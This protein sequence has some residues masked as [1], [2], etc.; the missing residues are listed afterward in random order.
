M[1][2]DLFVGLIQTYLDAIKYR[3]DEN[4]IKLDF[5]K[6]QEH[7]EKHMADLNEA[8]KIDNEKNRSVAMKKINAKYFQYVKH[9]IFELPTI[10][11]H[12]GTEEILPLEETL[13]EKIYGNISDSFT[14]INLNV[15]PQSIS[16]DPFNIIVN[17]M[18]ANSSTAELADTSIS[19]EDVST[20]NLYGGSSGCA[21]CMV[22]GKS[23]GVTFTDSRTKKYHNYIMVF[24][25]IIL[26][27]YYSGSADAWKIVEK[28][29]E[30]MNEL[31]AGY[32]KGIGDFAD[33][34][35]KQK[36][37]KLESILRR[38]MYDCYKEFNAIA[39]RINISTY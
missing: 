8:Q 2:K 24:Y 13:N 28:Y 35:S 31:E 6:Y 19:L 36:D 33:F 38:I 22:G 5:R 27:H 37:M 1:T 4:S 18:S 16:I 12:D 29:T 9:V 10:S 15:Y 34:P 23:P 26:H 14:P 17:S 32:E 30:K 20:L 7:H 21:G 25:N 3:I 11:I 39:S